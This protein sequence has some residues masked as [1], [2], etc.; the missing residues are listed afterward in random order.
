MYT[1][2]IIKHDF[3]GEGEGNLTSTTSLDKCKVVP[4]CTWMFECET[5]K[6]T[7]Y[8]VKDRKHYEDVLRE[9]TDFD[10]LRVL[11]IPKD[12]DEAFEFIIVTMQS[13]GAPLYT[14]VAGRVDMYVMNYKGI[15]IDKS[16]CYT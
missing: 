2:K 1:V 10:S 6:H 14:V 15:T 4:K 16:K 12:P 5:V 8:T 11:C 13:P 3:R 7:K 9:V